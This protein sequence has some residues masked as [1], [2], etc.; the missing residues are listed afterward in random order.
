VFAGRKRTHMD[1]RLFRDDI[2]MRITSVLFILIS[3]KNNNNVI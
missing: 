1:A 2:S 3:E